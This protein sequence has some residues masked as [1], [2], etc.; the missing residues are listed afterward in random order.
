MA[1][2]QEEIDRECD[3]LASELLEE[4][5]TGA[6]GLFRTKSPAHSIR[7]SQLPTRLRRRSASAE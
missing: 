5:F 4:Y 6:S 7:W 1:G 3:L 2:T